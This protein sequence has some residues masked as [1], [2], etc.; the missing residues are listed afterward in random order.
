MVNEAILIKTKKEISKFILDNGMSNIVSIYGIGSIAKKKD[1][2]GDIDL[3]IFLDN[4]DYD[5]IVQINS[6]KL[7][8]KEKLEKDIDF[9][10]IDMSIVRDNLL[11]SDIFPHKNRHSLFLYELSILDCLIYGEPLLDGIKFDKE[12]LKKECVKLTLTLVQR[13]NKEMLTKMSD[14]TPI[15]GRKFSKYAIEFAMISRGIKNPYFLSS[16][17]VTNVLQVIPEISEYSELM[18]DI[19]N[20]KTIPLRDSYNFIRHVSLILKA[21]YIK[22]FS[23]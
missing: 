10:I 23:K 6:L 18:E 7:Y 15:N 9:N 2:V 17:E 5:S 21:D 1:N 11:E 12:D 3:N 16:S 13:L 22:K 8:L 14:R 19:L 4:C 20:C